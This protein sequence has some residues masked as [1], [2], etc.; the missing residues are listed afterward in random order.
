MVFLQPGFSSTEVEFVGKDDDPE[1]KKVD[2]RSLQK[3]LG[4][5]NMHDN[6]FTYLQM[7]GSLKDKDIAFSK[8]NG[9][10]SLRSPTS[11]VIANVN[12]FYEKLS[13]E[14][15][16]PIAPEPFPTQQKIKYTEL[17]ESVQ[18]KL[19][20]VVDQMKDQ[21]PSTGGGETV[22]PFSGAAAAASPP[23]NATEASLEDANAATS[24]FFGMG[25]M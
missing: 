4:G 9:S 8:Q 14:T 6:E 11:L 22:K 25:G 21:L 10:L 15:G 5:Q 3:F 23:A 18:S 1:G 13:E 24:N 2:F 7:I 20:N 12:K 17:V 16:V 19:R